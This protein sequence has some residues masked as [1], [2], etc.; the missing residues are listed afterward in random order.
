MQSLN[1]EDQLF[2]ATLGFYLNK[3]YNNKRPPDGIFDN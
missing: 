1:N 2:I 3:T